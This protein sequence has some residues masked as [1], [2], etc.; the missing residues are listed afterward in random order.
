MKPLLLLLAAVTF[1][2]PK[3]VSHL[4]PHAAPA[5]DPSVNRGQDLEQAARGLDSA[6]PRERAG[7]VDA[8]AALGTIGAWELV[9]ERGLPDTNSRVAD[10]AQLRLAEADLS[11]ELVELVGG[12]SGLGSKRPLIRVRVAQALATMGGAA[13]V[14]LLERGLKDKEAAV[15]VAL[16]R[17]LERRAPAGEGA[18]SGSA[19]EWKR[20]MAALERLARRDRESVAQA[21]GLLALDA[22]ARHLGRGGEAA[23]EATAEALG[24]DDPLLVA[25]ALGAAPGAAGLED[26][27][28]LLWRKKV[29]HAALM[30][31]VR[32]AEARGDR[33]GARL[34]VRRLADAERPLRPAAAWGLVRALR[35]MSGLS[36]GLSAERWARWSADLPEG[37]VVPVERREEAEQGPTTTTL[38]GLTVYGD[39][40]AFLVDMSG[41]MWVD[42]KGR[43]RKEAVDE[44]LA[45]CLRALPPTARFDV[46]PYA[47]H[48]DPWRGELVDATPK[49]VERAVKTFL[50][51]SLNGVGDL[52]TAIESVLA[53]PEVDTIVVLSDGAPSGG[54]R[55]NVE[56]MGALL[57]EEL[58]LRHVDLQMVLFGPTKG[59][60]RRWQKVVEELGGSI[61]LID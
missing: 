59:L 61:A 3:P 26:L 32:A 7:A 18:F 39:R 44:E 23:A 16:A 43:P 58:R 10:S 34:L 2:A 24:G 38:Y 9:V 31:A 6:K 1:E 8:L 5:V 60:K 50:T 57:G 28:A 15:R 45:R 22:C 37:P 52:W 36:I 33:E 55:W 41:S 53:D 56:L 46:V 54:D 48:P 30:A 4:R 40:V 11:A 12:R 49:N 27:E 20:F 17:A 47:K 14:R 42:H 19:A 25:A 29:E 13:P 51:C 35:R 21:A